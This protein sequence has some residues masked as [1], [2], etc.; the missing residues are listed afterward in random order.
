[1]PDIFALPAGEWHI[2]AARDSSLL[3]RSAGAGATPDDARVP[4]GHPMVRCLMLLGENAPR[5]AALWAAKLA[6]KWHDTVARVITNAAPRVGE[7]ECVD[8]SSHF[9]NS[10]LVPR[11]LLNCKANLSTRIYIIFLNTYSR[12]DTAMMSSARLWRRLSR[13]PG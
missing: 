9:F 12:N 2:L 13:C 1:V 4:L 3:L 10:R 5:E 6:P 11:F 8:V 7:A